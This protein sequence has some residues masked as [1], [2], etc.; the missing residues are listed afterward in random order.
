MDLKP[1]PIMTKG[2]VCELLIAVMRAQARIP[3]V[4]VYTEE[5]LAVRRTG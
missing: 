1:I 2:E 3:G 5:S 4:R